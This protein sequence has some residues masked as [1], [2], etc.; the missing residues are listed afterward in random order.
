LTKR[1]AFQEPAPK[2]AG[3]LFGLEVCVNLLFS[4]VGVKP[5]AQF[6][7]LW[8]TLIGIAAVQESVLIRDEPQAFA[9]GAI[10]LFQHSPL[11]PESNLER[12]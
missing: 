4:L 6:T 8:L 5:V 2:E 9:Q 7:W 3:F 1:K 10:E 11:G 12:F